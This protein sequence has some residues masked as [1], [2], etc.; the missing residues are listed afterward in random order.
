MRAIDTNVL[1]RY[2]MNDDPPQA[3]LASRFLEE[4]VANREDVY[5]SVPVLCEFFWVLERTYRYPKDAI[6]FALETLLLIPFFQFD[7]HSALRIAI[8]RYR[9]GRA[10]L[11]DYLIG[12]LAAQ[13]GCRDTVT[14]D[15][16]LRGATGF[17][18]LRAT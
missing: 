17:A 14:F 9:Q 5:I 2:L 11:A 8:D 16:G 4:C 12:E 6:L 3:A 1:V 10:G 7:Q 18:I 13:A 15:R